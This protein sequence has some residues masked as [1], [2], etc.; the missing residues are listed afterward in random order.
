[1]ATIV[2]ILTKFRVFIGWSQNFIP[3]PLIFYEASRF[4]VSHRMDAPDR[5]NWQRH[6]RTNEQAVC[7]FVRS[8]LRW[9]LTHIFFG[10]GVKLLTHSLIP[11]RPFLFHL[12]RLIV[13]CLCYTG[14]LKWCAEYSVRV[15]PNNCSHKNNNKNDDDDNNKIDDIYSVFGC[16]KA[17]WEF[18]QVTWMNVGRRQVMNRRVRRSK[19]VQTPVYTQ[20]LISQPIRANLYKYIKGVHWLGSC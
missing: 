4:V 7:P 6:K 18:T 13:S 2:M 20:L 5:H 3:F 1:M 12:H 11:D 19:S 17:P 8:S 9:S 16:G 10:W 14:Q 15:R